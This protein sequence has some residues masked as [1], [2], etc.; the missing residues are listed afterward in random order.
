MTRTTVLWSARRRLAASIG[1]SALAL[2]VLVGAATPATA[3][4][5]VKASVTDGTLRITG[6]P[7]ADHIALRMSPLDRTQLQVDVGDD[8]SADRTFDL[9]TF[10]A[11]DVETRGGDD[12][13][14]IDEANGAF[15]TTT[16]TRIDGGRGDDTLR[17]GSGA[18]L[19]IGGGGNDLI[20]GNGGAD[21]AFLG[22]GDD[23]FVWDPGDGSDVVEGQSG[24]DTLTFNGSAGNE[25]ME[26]RANFGR[27]AFTRNL[28]NILMDL[29]GIE[30]IDVRALGGSDAVTVDNLGGTDVSRVNV[31]LAAANGG[32]TA[33]GQPDTVTVG[34][35]K[36]DDSIAVDADGA[37][38]NVTG[39]AAF[40]RITHADPASDALVI[41]PVTGVDHVA[42]DPAVNGLIQASI[43]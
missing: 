38:V 22:A 42:I 26:A 10:G 2:V 32:S 19:F 17:G 5:S 24:S 37:A 23:V 9:N 36:G 34:G 3:A 39:L 28:G 20:D 8:G 16:T 40:V 43:Q 15:T 33:D 31:D 41:E 6:G 27:V 30:A 4:P 29:D 12:S 13:V 18:E 7:F 11:I 1:A 35:T 25:I 14:R 21:T